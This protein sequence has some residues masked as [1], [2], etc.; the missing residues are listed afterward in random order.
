VSARYPSAEQLMEAAAT[1]TGLD[2]FGPGDF[3]E[4][5]EVL[6]ASLTADAGLARSTDEQVL[7]DLSRRLRNRLLVEQWYAEHP[8]LEALSPSGPVDVCGLPR[9][10]TTAVGNMLSLDPQLRPMR[11]WEQANPVPPPVLATEATD[12]RRLAAIQAD[13]DLPPEAHAKHLYDADAALEDTDVLG[14]AFHGQQMVLPVY[15]YHDWWRRSDMRE[16]FGYHRRIAVLL[17]SQRP[18]D[19]WLFKCPHHKFH[20]EH[21]VD[22]YPDARFVWT[23]RD[24]AKVVPSYASLVGSILP[25]AASPDGHD[26]VRLGHEICDHLRIGT[27]MAMEQRDRLGEE[28]FLDV[29]HADLHLDPMGTMQSIY[30][31]LGLELT[32]DV[33]AALAEWQRVN[34][35]GAHGDHRYSAE[36]FGLTAEQIRDDYEPYIRRFDVPVG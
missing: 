5:L 28:R 11:G 21:L 19:L 2:D 36:Q 31:F 6:L 1:E 26:Q 35:S 18:P 32:A 10:G 34:R 4:G 7:G 3:R 27:E 25:E 8:E 16:A 12:P 24:P 17:Q 23:H 20:L 33:E 30:D 29:H 15:G 9:T 14:M 13:E 22:A